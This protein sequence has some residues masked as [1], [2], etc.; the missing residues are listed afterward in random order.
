MGIKSDNMEEAE[1]LGGTG[2][3]RAMHLK[4]ASSICLSGLFAALLHDVPVGSR[5]LWYLR[6]PSN[7][8]E[9][10]PL[11]ALAL[12]LPGRVLAPMQGI[13]SLQ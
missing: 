11:N 4:L 8:D 7:A 1:L 6:F 9:V 2:V 10:L 13:R 12:S 5:C 3:G